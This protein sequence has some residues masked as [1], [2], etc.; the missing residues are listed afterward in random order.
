[1]TCHNARLHAADLQLDAVDVEHPAANA[2]T[3]EKVLRKL[4]AR[5][6]PP[7]GM[8]HPDTA[9]YES[10]ARYLETALDQAAAATPNPGRPAAYRLSRFQYANAVR[11]LIALDV[12]AA[13]LLP[14]DD[15]GYGFDNIGDVLTV[16]PMLLEKYLS[17]A[18][19]ISRLAVGDPS[20]EPTS[21]EFQIPPPP[22]RPTAKAAT[23]QSAPA[24]ALR[25][26]ITFR[27]TLNTSSRSGLQ[28]GKDAT[29]IVGMSEPRQLDIRLDGRRLRLFT[30]GGPS[31]RCSRYSG[32][33]DDG[34]E[35]RI[36]VAAG[37]HEVASTF[38]KDTVKPEGVLDRAGNQAFFEGVGSVSIAG[39][40]APTGSGDTASRRKIFVCRPR[41]QR[42]DED[43]CATRI[44]TTLAR[45]AYRRP[46]TKEEI[47]SLMTPHEGGERRRRVRS[48]NQAG[49]AK[50]SRVA[51]FSVPDRS[52]SC[53]RSVRLRLS[54]QRR[55][56]RV[57]VYRFSSGAAAR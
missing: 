32:D 2:A 12:D 44:I 45:R 7:P 51:G 24:A 30:V 52:R 9:T 3:W 39:P 35:V 4:R 6:M 34:L 49:G 1:M 21:T 43:A 42:S 28:R 53:K 57:T 15:S 11:D 18:A 38:V 26:A 29:T 25:F 50:D 22:C 46:I 36:P 17:A 56:A 48:W 27:W 31:A 14:A 19:K 33:L 10:L 55:G 40:Y 23:C 20:L 13:S 5:D 16:S 41:G 47:P 54:H 8:P 37:S